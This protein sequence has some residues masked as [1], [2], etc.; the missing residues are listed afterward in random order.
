M[1]L[2]IHHHTQALNSIP[3]FRLVRQPDHHLRG[4]HLDVYPLDTYVGFFLA[5]Q[6]IY[7]H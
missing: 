7:L 2:N 3:S 4:H 6:E 5:P 1:F